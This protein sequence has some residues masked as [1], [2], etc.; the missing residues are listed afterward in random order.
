MEVIRSALLT[1]TIFTS[2]DP[3]SRA[4]RVGPR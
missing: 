1:R 4:A 3:H 2:S